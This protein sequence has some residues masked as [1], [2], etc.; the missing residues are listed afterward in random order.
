MRIKTT[1]NKDSTDRI[2]CVDIRVL[3][4]LLQKLRAAREK[5]QGRAKARDH[6]REDEVRMFVS[7]QV[8]K[9]Q[10]LLP[11]EAGLRFGE[12]LQGKE[13]RHI[14]PPTSCFKNGR[15]RTDTGG[16]CVWYSEWQRVLVA[17]RCAA[18][19]LW[20]HTVH[21][22]I[23][24]AWHETLHYRL[25]NSLH[26]HIS[27]HEYTY[28]NIHSRCQNRM[29]ATTSR[30]VKV[31]AYIHMKLRSVLFLVARWIPHS[32]RRNIGHLPTSVK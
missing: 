12:R 19:N 3:C 17:L 15:Y 5:P 16:E 1:L 31:L 7:K 22:V 13:G 20:K 11:N 21:R 30:I 10:D 27:S 26:Q 4:S 24:T 28:R 29:H 6:A 2:L 25:W 14:F 23:H 18:R 8:E 32:P 9:R